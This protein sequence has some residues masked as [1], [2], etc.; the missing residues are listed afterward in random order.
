MEKTK[1]Q[2][3]IPDSA[4]KVFEGVLFDVYQWEQEMFDGSM[5]IFERVTH[6]GTCIV[7]ALTEDKKVVVLNQEQPYKG[8]YLSLPGGR[9]E[10]GE[11]V[12]NTAK[13]ELL[14]ETG[15]E[16]GEITLWHT[17]C[18]TEKIVW[19]LYFF[20]AKNCKKVSQQ[21]LDAGEK[22]NVHLVD[23]DEFLEMIFSQKIKSSEFIMKFLKE[24]LLVIDKE[25]TLEKIKKHFK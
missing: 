9:V 11:D 6:P 24:D 10:E 5:G 3:S 13:R 18:M 23:I 22:I 16:C 2:Q 7:V 1:S 4:K 19:N 14:E 15:Y 8:K 21:N 12:M 20:V 25:K 17:G